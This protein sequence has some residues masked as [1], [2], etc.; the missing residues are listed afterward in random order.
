[1]WLHLLEINS[2]SV[3][4]YIYACFIRNL[5]NI[6]QWICVIFVESF[7]LKMNSLLKVLFVHCWNCI[8]CAFAPHWYMY[9]TTLQE[10]ETILA[11]STKKFMTWVFMDH[12]SENCLKSLGEIRKCVSKLILQ[13]N[14][15][16]RVIWTTLELFH[17]K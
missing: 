13:K 9:I 3:H 7:Y 4:T 8:L 2:T 15:L 10:Y 11:N 1:M 12:H 14:F 5:S 17:S 16:K 6:Q